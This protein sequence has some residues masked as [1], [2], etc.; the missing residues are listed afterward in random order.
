M[1]L[2]LVE[3]ARTLDALWHL[4]SAAPVDEAEAGQRGREVRLAGQRLAQMP[5]GLVKRAG[6]RAS[7][8]HAVVNDRVQRVQLQRARV[9]GAGAA[10]VARAIL[11]LAQRQ[12][13]KRAR[14]IAG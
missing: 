14:G 10:E 11:A 8:A 5:L 13:G 6:L 4:F 9:N 3:G 2:G 7:V 1:T 12:E